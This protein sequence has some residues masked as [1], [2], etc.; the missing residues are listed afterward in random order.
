LAAVAREVRLTEELVHRDFTVDAPDRR[1]FADIAE[2]PSDAGKL[3]LASVL[4]AFDKQIVSWSI[5]ENATSSL[6]VNAARDGGRS[7][8]SGH[9]TRAS[10]DRGTQYTSIAFRDRLAK[11]GLTPSMGSRGDA[12]G[13][14][15]I[16]SWRDPANRAARSAAVAD[17]RSVQDGVVPLHRDLLPSSSMALE[18]R[19]LASRRIRMEGRAIAS[20]RE[21]AQPKPS[22]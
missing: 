21:N 10:S 20:G 8:P 15:L 11:L 14:A 1:W 17:P 13:N 19:A 18:P 2:R 4:D 16:E 12:D 7:P 9:P 22:K 3:Y 5:A 6:V